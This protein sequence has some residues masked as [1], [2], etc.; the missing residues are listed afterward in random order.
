[1]DLRSPKLYRLF[2]NPKNDTLIRP[3]V[4]YINRSTNKFGVAINSIS[5]NI[6]TLC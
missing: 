5:Y 1:M 6:T 3:V 2:K 4:V